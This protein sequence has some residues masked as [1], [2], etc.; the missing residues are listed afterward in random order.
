MR[1]IAFWIM[2]AI[3]LALAGIYAGSIRYGLMAQNRSGVE[4]E[5]M[6]GVC[7]FRWSNRSFAPFCSV[8]P[9]NWGHRRANFDGNFSGQIYMR[10]PLYAPLVI[11]A[12]IAVVLGWPRKRRVPTGCSACGYDLRG[13]MPGPAGVR[14]PECGAAQASPAAAAMNKLE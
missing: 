2:L 10:F 9:H 8:E 1:R 5:V 13:Q 11:V 6:G 12:V 14:C 3:T 4:L 7:I